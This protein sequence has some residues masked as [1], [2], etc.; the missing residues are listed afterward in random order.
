MQV[1]QIKMLSFQPKHHFTSLSLRRIAMG[2]QIFG[3]TKCFDTKKAERYFKERKIKYQFVDIYKYGLS[4]GEFASV[5]AAVG[6]ND[7]INQNTSDY[8]KL[9]LHHI[10]GSSVREE[11]LFNNPK[12]YKTPIVRNGKKATVGYQPDLWKDWE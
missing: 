9:N 6:L 5:K 8:K 12:L 2:I 1:Q 3:T 11:I 4:K 10:G 7:L